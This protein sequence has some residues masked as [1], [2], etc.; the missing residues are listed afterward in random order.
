RIP[1]MAGSSVP[2]AE[3]RPPIEFPSGAVVEEAVWIHGGG[4]ESYDCHAFEVMQ[5]LIEARR[6]GE[7]GV[8]EVQLLTGEACQKAAAEGR[9]SST[10]VTAAMNAERNGQMKRRPTL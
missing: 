9:W 7:T 3:R 2:L 1:L 8:K 6:G 5:S 4:V 10:L